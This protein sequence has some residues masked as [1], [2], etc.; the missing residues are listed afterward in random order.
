MRRTIRFSP[1]VVVAAS[2][3]LSLGACNSNGGS[4]PSQP[5]Y[6]L[7]VRPILMAHCAR[8]HGAGGNLNLPTEPTGPNAPVLPNLQGMAATEFQTFDCYLDRWGNA[9]DCNFDGGVRPA[10]C[11]LGAK[12]WAGTI[13]GLLRNPSPA[14]VMPPP[15]ASL[16]DDW[17]VDILTN[18]AKESPLICSHSSNPDPAICPD[19]P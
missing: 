3:L 10:S 7:D 13:P 17:E 19:G 9:G 15:P 2:A 16:V 6:D 11:K 5:A 12:N 14:S 1:L 4:I 8:C 18:W